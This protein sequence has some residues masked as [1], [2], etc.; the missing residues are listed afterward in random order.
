M[1]LHK[2]SEC[3]L[4]FDKLYG[5][6]ITNLPCAC[7]LKCHLRCYERYIQFAKYCPNCLDCVNHDEWFIVLWT[8]RPSDLS[9]FR[10]INQKY[11][12]YRYYYVPYYPDMSELKNKI[13][14]E[15]RY[16]AS[17]I[18]DNIYEQRIVIKKKVK[19]CLINLICI[20]DLTDI[21]IGYF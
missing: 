2:N 15:T 11:F 9:L 16:L 10:R 12:G 7:N 21:V 13:G 20:N 17:K 1:E 8:L 6:E 19:M 18:M 3:Y 4:C 5:G 14:G